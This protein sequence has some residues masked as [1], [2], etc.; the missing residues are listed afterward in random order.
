MGEWASGGS[1][2]VG[3]GVGRSP[4]LISYFVAHKSNEFRINKQ[5][6]CTRIGAESGKYNK[7]EKKIKYLHMREYEHK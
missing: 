6:S 2:R 1:R 5:Q 7:K 3:D 4:E